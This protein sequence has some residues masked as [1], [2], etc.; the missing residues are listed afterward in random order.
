VVESGVDVGGEAQQRL[1][2]V[3]RCQRVDVGE[4]SGF[5]AVEQCD[6]FAAGEFVGGEG[7]SDDAGGGGHA[8]WGVQRQIDQQVLGP[9]DEQSAEGVA[10]ADAV[11]GPVPSMDGVIELVSGVGD[12]ALAAGGEEIQVPGWGG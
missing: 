2:V 11:D 9:A 12:T 8:G 3:M 6:E 7:G 1:L 4:V 10:V 5:C